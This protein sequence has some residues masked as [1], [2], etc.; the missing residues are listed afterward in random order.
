MNGNVAPEYGGIAQSIAPYGIIMHKSM[1]NNLQ[2]ILMLKTK[3]LLKPWDIKWYQLRYYLA[4]Y[5][6][7]GNFRTAALHF[8]CCDTRYW[9]PFYTTS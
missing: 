2:F 6:W 5:Y 4:I 8:T 3:K 9:P 1:Q 7:I